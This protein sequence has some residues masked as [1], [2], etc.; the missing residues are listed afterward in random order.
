MRLEIPSTLPSPQNVLPIP[1]A[2]LSQ[3]LL[4]VSPAGKLTLT[5]IAIAAVGQEAPSSASCEIIER[6]VTQGATT[7][8]QQPAP[9]PS[10]TAHSTAATSPIPSPEMLL[11]TPVSFCEPVVFRPH[12]ILPLP[13]VAQTGPRVPKPNKR[14]GASRCHTSSPEMRR[15]REQ[16]DEKQRKEKQAEYRKSAV[17]KKSNS[18]K[19]KEVKD[20]II[21]TIFSL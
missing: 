20:E 10:T 11:S 14:L 1:E 2:P 17:A 12:D 16:Y 13:Q 9:S 18:T 3:Y 7:E 4:S 5:P 19:Q 15:I 21:L 8:Q 6:A